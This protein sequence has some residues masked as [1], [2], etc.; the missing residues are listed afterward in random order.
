MPPTSRI[1]STVTMTTKTATASDQR[2]CGSSNLRRSKPGTVT[3]DC[4]VSKA[5][6]TSSAR[7]KR[8]PGSFSRQRSITLC[9]WV[10][11]TPPGPACSGSGV[12]LKMAELSSNPVFP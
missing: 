3:P 1:A 11:S 8:R 10:G 6:R 12:V 9:I 4:T 2:W 7:W 5:A